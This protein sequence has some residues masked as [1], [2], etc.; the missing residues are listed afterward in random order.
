M[1]YPMTQT[2]IL[3]FFWNQWEMVSELVNLYRPLSFAKALIFLWCAT[4]V[5]S[6]STHALVLSDRYFPSSTSP[7]PVWQVFS[8]SNTSLSVESCRKEWNQQTE[9]L[10]IVNINV[11]ILNELDTSRS[12]Q[13]SSATDP[14]P[15][16]QARLRHRSWR[17]SSAHGIL[18]DI[19]GPICFVP[20]ELDLYIGLNARE[21]IEQIGSYFG[22]QHRLRQVQRRKTVWLPKIRAKKSLPT[23]LSYLRGALQRIA[24]SS[25]AASARSEDTDGRCRASRVKSA[26]AIAALRFRWTREEM[27]LRKKMITWCM[28]SGTIAMSKTAKSISEE[29]H[30]VLRVERGRIP[31]FIKEE[32]LSF[33]KS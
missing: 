32:N 22:L 12:T 27:R 26:A 7:M 8:F 16:W 17:S 19:F 24:R 28:T 4:F 10:C 11:D 9:T 18:N 23:R 3:F 33:G 2:T 21:L 29:K 1:D 31:D 25:T 14:R 13:T 20:S 6:W 15:P 30:P 5:N